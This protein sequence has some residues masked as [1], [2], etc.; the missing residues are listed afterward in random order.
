VQVGGA[1]LEVRAVV[2]SSA[3]TIDQSIARSTPASRGVTTLRSRSAINAILYPNESIPLQA[4]VA[5]TLR[6]EIF[7]KEAR[8]NVT[9]N[10]ETSAA[11]MKCAT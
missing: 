6:I 9:S 11:V 3:L 4:K 2:I 10:L 1:H 7:S 5:S 8:F